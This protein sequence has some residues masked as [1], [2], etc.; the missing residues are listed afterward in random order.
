MS[1]TMYEPLAGLEIPHAPAHQL[2]DMDNAARQ[3]T[4][5]EAH[6]KALKKLTTAIHVA[7]GNGATWAEIA[8]VIDQAIPDAVAGSDGRLAAI[9]RA[10]VHGGDDSF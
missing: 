5:H 4:R 10:K 3:A 7:V 1:Q 6:A 9:L 2:D 8:E